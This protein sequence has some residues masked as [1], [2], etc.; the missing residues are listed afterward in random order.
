MSDSIIYS[1]RR[2]QT[3][4]CPRYTPRISDLTVCLYSQHKQIKSGKSE[5]RA[6]RGATLNDMSE[7]GSNSHLL[8]LSFRNT[9]QWTCL[10]LLSKLFMR[11]GYVLISACMN[12]WGKESENHCLE[13]WLYCLWENRVRWCSGRIICA[14]SQLKDSLSTSPCALSPPAVTERLV[15]VLPWWAE[16]NTSS[17][18]ASCVFHLN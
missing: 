16:G 3:G 4:N 2:S 5:N 18:P 11:P 9:N 6:Q 13:D 1:H 8:P 7:V 10:S 14:V 15:H 12:S 17:H